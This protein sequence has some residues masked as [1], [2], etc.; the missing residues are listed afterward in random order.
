MVAL[1]G[2]HQ[3]EILTGNIVH[4]NTRKHNNEQ[5]YYNVNVLESAIRDKKR[6]PFMY[7]DLDENLNKVYRKDK[8]IYTVEPIALVFNNDNY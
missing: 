8:A 7:F 5:I 1:G 2:S 6:V 3:A 4:F